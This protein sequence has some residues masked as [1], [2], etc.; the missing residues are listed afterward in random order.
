MDTYKALLLERIIENWDK[1]YVEFLKMNH[2]MDK[3]IIKAAFF[4]AAEQLVDRDPFPEKDIH[5]SLLARLNDRKY[6]AME[7]YLEE[8]ELLF[9]DVVKSSRLAPP[10]DTTLPRLFPR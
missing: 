4:S 7:N 10:L 6:N 9:T 8:V 1:T 2:L 3:P 5:Q